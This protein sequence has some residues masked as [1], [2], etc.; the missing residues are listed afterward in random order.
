MAEP[1]LAFDAPVTLA[2][3]GPAGGEDL[4]DALAFAPRLVCADGGANRIGGRTPDAIVGDLDSLEDIDDWRA[5]L[6]D[7]LVGLTE[8]DTTDLEKCLR[9]ID[10]P[11]FIGAG[12]L[13]GRVDHLLAALHALVAEPRP[14]ALIGADD[15]L[16]AAASHV[17]LDLEPGDRVS[18]FPM[19]GVRAL[20]SAGLEWPVDGLGFEAGAKIGTSNRAAAARV[21]ITFD[22]PGAVIAAPRA[23]L[24]RVIAAFRR[25]TDCAA[26]PSG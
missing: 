25:A 14:V 24:D 13:A 10:A 5:R 26:G 22:R 2:G 3:G 17:A 7:R 11:F 23:R 9:V 6:G 18:I 16:F 21:E 4:S 19:R 8:Q 15:A 20:K 12:F 1:R